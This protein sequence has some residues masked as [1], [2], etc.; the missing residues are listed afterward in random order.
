MANPLGDTPISSHPP[1]GHERRVA[2]LRPEAVAAR[3][4]WLDEGL[5][6]DAVAS[7]ELAKHL[8]GPDP[9]AP[10]KTSRTSA[11]SVVS[12]RLSWVRGVRPR[13]LDRRAGSVRSQ[14]PPSETLTFKLLQESRGRVASLAVGH[15][16][17]GG[18]T[19]PGRHGACAVDPDKKGPCV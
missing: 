8:P 11:A 3:S 7:E 4:I 6:L 17:C 1:S 5:A 19:T 16:V 15:G 10:A 13:A 9:G 14:A 2:A 18:D 12:I